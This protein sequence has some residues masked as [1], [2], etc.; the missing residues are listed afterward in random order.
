MALHT[1]IRR[2]ASSR[3]PKQKRATLSRI[4]EN[5]PARLAHLVIV[6]LVSLSLSSRVCISSSSFSSF[7]PFYSL[8]FQKE[9]K[10]KKKE[11]SLLV[12]LASFLLSTDIVSFENIAPSKGLH[13]NCPSFRHH[14][15]RPWRLAN[16]W[17]FTWNTSREKQTPLARSTRYFSTFDQLRFPSRTPFGC[18]MHNASSKANLTSCRGIPLWIAPCHRHTV[19]VPYDANTLDIPWRHNKP[20]WE[21]C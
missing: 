18:T 14:R 6:I 7:I 21:N 1:K 8:V 20:I 5:L 19:G 11:K 10:R 2:V 13:G 9:R 3:V 4:E 17:T 15:W 16:A 12:F